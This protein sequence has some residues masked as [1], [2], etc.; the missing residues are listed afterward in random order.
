M[1]EIGKI[2]TGLCKR[3]NPDHVKA[4]RS[5]HFALGEHESWTVRI[6]RE[7]CIVERGEGEEADVYFRGPAQLFLDVWNGRHQLGPM[8]FISGASRATSPCC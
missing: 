5:Y 8:D 4:E 1:T 3:F 6:T 2:F 7:K